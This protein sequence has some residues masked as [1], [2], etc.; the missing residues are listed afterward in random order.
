MVRTTLGGWRLSKVVAVWLVMLVGCW[1]ALLGFL[2]LV[3]NIR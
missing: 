1:S 2:W 3:L